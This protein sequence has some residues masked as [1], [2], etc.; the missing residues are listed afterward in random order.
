MICQKLQRHGEQERVHVL[1][2]MGDLDGILG[3]APDLFITLAA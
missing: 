3:P 1:V 2:D